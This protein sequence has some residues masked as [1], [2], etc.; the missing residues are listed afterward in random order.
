MASKNFILKE[1][2]GKWQAFALAGL[3]VLIFGAFIWGVLMANQANTVLANVSKDK[4]ANIYMETADTN[5]AMLR[6]LM[7][8]DRIIPIL[9]VFGS[10]GKHAIHSHF[11]KSEFDAIYLSS[12]GF[13]VEVIRK[14]PPN[15]DWVEPNATNFYLLELPPD[16]TDKLAIEKG[17]KLTWKNISKA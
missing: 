9:F 14:I 4:T 10:E 15:K 2:A 12:D 6:G 5:L 3:L 7:F 17:D 13:A 8:R 16:I 1:N 11:V